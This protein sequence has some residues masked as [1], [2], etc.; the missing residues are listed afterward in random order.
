MELGE[1]VQG[2]A[3][4]KRRDEGQC[5]TQGTQGEATGWRRDEAQSKASLE[6][7]GDRRTS[8]CMDRRSERWNS[9]DCGSVDRSRVGGG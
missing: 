8:N 1:E 3:A 2:K 6:Q 7:G 9:G 4:G 5:S